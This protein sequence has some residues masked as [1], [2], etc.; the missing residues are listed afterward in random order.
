M[1]HKNPSNRSPMGHHKGAHLRKG[2]HKKPQVILTPQQA[3]ERLAD[4]FYNHE[5]GHISRDVQAQLVRFYE[6]LMNQQQKENFTRLLSFRDVAI[7]HFI[8]CLIIPQ[9]TQLTFPLL[10]M[11]TGPGFPGI[12]LR[13]IVPQENK[14]IL[15]EGVQKRVEFLKQVREELKLENLDILGK[16]ITPAFVYP[17]NGVITRA[18]EDVGNTLKNVLNCLKVGGKVFLMKGPGVDPE[19][20][21]A[22][23]E[24]GQHYELSQDTAYTLPHSPHER[25]L[26][27]FT[28]IKSAEVIP[29]EE[30]DDDDF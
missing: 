25:R 9:L 6:L 1:A 5:F 14:I 21:P 20:Q 27:V 18:V 29:E 30:I 24:W 2:N 28:K 4:I 10:D 3:E 11:G 15:A 16:N 23:K 17:V 12:P 26:L 13:L 7:K 22:L 8:D 19:I